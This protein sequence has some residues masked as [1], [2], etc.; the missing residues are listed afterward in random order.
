M[1]DPGLLFPPDPDNVRVTRRDPGAQS[2]PHTHEQFNTHELT[3]DGVVD[4]AEVLAIVQAQ[5]AIRA[6]G[7]IRTEAG[8]Q[9]VQGVGPRIEIT[10]P[11]RDIDPDLVGRVVIIHR[12]DGHHEHE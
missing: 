9:V 5:G 2:A 4:P 7:F 11:E 12:T 10:D 6:K 3:F 8:V 1:V